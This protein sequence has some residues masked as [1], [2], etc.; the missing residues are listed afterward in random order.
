MCT[1]DYTPQLLKE[2]TKVV[3]VS[4]DSEK[5]MDDIIKDCPLRLGNKIIKCMD[6]EELFK[7]FFADNQIKKK[8]FKKNSVC[9]SIKD[10]HPSDYSRIKK[11][12]SKKID[13]KLT[14]DLAR[15]PLN[16]NNRKSDSRSIL[17]FS[18][19][20]IFDYNDEK[21]LYTLLNDYYQTIQIKKKTN[22]SKEAYTILKLD[23]MLMSGSIIPQNAQ[24]CS[25][26]GK[27][28]NLHSQ[29]G[30][31]HFETQVHSKKT[32][33]PIPVTRYVQEVGVAPS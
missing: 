18:E 1:Q 4:F 29:F 14:C 13:D 26:D 25:N 22:P 11:S 32:S 10:V 28:L 30:F 27:K 20:K 31:S 7:E 21:S 8:F 15:L 2:K 5:A 12:I 6:I 19:A 17:E 16:T 9:I 33:L 23:R 3:K 24:F